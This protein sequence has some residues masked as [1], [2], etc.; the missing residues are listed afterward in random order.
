MS[1]NTKRSKP[2]L[3]HSSTQPLN[4]T[5]DAFISTPSYLVD[6]HE[7]HPA[8]ASVMPH[9]RHSEKPPEAPLQAGVLLC[10][11]QHLRQEKKKVGKINARKDKQTKKKKTS[12]YKVIHERG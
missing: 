3:S 10:Q 8:E 2:K 4:L 5:A 1:I 9:D 12:I 11:D 6:P 7:V